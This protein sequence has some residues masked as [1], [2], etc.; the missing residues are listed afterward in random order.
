MESRIKNRYRSFRL[1]FIFQAF[2][3]DDP[4]SNTTCADIHC[5][6]G[7]PTGCYGCTGCMAPGEFCA[8]LDGTASFMGPI[9]PRDKKPVGVRLAQAGAVVAYG[10]PGAATGPTLSGCRVDGAT[11]TLAFNT[12]LLGSDNVSVVPGE[13]QTWPGASKVHVLTDPSLFCM[14][15]KG[16]GAGAVCIDD[17]TGQGAGPGPWDDLKKTW[18]AVDIAQAGPNT[19]TVD[20]T[21][22]GGKAYAIRYAWQ[23]GGPRGGYCCTE[24][25]VNHTSLQRATHLN[26]HHLSFFDAASKSRFAMCFAPST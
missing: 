26:P 20:L 3:L 9:H 12:T 19:V 14:Q 13:W 8:S 17:G 6:T 11:I 2:D 25:S 23:V 16:Q 5:C 10:H 4:W 7:Q 21:K 24:R 18:V 15:T 22:A 1:Y